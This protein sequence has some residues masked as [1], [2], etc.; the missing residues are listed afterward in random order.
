MNKVTLR[1]GL[2][3]LLTAALSF[4][5]VTQAN[6]ADLRIGYQK[7]GTLVLL[8]ANGELDRRLAEQGVNVRWIEFPAGPQLLEGLNVGAVDFGTTG[9][10]PPVF[11]QAAGAD[12]LYVAHEPPAPTS[13]AILVPSDSPITSV[14]ELQGKRIAL[15]KGSN[16]HY[17][18]VRALE[19]AGLSIDDI[20]PVYL[21]PADARAA[22]ERN[23]VDAWV[24]WDP[25]QSAAEQ[26][27]GAR[28]LANGEGLV[29]NY[30]FYLSTRSYA[31]DNPQVLQILLEEIEAIGNW[32][33]DNPDEAVAQVAPL[34]GLSPE[35]TRTALLRQGYG[36]RP[37]SPEVIRAQQDIA[38]TF[39]QLKLIPRE[40]NISEVVWAPPTH[41]A[42]N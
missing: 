35:I 25:F 2:A 9:E 1:R 4:G 34:L 31:R 7:Y 15:N 11:A 28:T 36:P 17:L 6:A 37:L 20:T 33:R 23:S 39:Y 29:S 21:P 5:A 3:A 14:A 22:F 41:T 16:V 32:T 40:L 38:D 10:T 30:Q 26:Q 27:I 12:L 13:E 42:A 24:I 18:L 8:K 19:Q